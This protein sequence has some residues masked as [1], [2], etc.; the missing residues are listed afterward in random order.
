MPVD[1]TATEIIRRPREQVAAYLRDPGNDTEWIG[2]VRRTR[3]LS[4]GPVGV[5]SQV[6]R[7]ASFLGR[8]VEYVNEIT[9]LDADQLAMRSVRSPFPMRVTYGHRDAGNGT[10]EVSV[11]VEGDARRFYALAAPLLAPA[12]RRSI[13]RDLRTLKRILEAAGPSVH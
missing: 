13:S 8:R 3:I 12:V 7:V 5:G 10:T 2:G 11:K 6:E 9:E 4:S 1:V